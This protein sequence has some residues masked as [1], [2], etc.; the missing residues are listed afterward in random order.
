MLINTISFDSYNVVKGDTATLAHHFV[1]SNNYLFNPNLRI[2]REIYYQSLFNIPITKHSVNAF[3]MINETRATTTDAL[4][5][6]GTGENYGV[7]VSVEKF[8][9]NRYYFLLSSSFFKSKYTGSDGIER[10][11]RW[12]S[13]VNGTFTG[14]KEFVLSKGSD[15]TLLGFNTKVT[16]SGGL[17]TTPIDLDASIAEGTTIF[18]ESQTFSQQNPAYFRIDAGM[19]LKLNRKKVTPASDF[20]N[21]FAQCYNDLL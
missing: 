19:S 4:V 21:L 20:T 1:L 13:N 17:R 9:S 15:N 8:L 3:S 11:T 12:S 2:K 6:K 10:N 5:N 18:D 16:Y 14:G 7:E